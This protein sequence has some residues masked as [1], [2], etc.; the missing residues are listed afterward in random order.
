MSIL[1]GTPYEAIKHMDGLCYDGFVLFDIFA[2]SF[3]EALNVKY[4][5]YLPFHLTTL[6]QFLSNPILLD[7]TP[8]KS[9]Y[10]LNDL[11]LFAVYGMV[12]FL[13]AILGT[14][15]PMLGLAKQDNMKWVF[16]SGKPTFVTEGRLIFC[17]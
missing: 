16:S 15:L 2:Q 11:C 13:S 7:F 6:F 1:I 5:V 8:V 3:E 14:M 12:P 9:Y 10:F 4:S 17:N